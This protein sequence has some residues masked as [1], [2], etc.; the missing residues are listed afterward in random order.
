MKRLAPAEKNDPNS[1]EDPTEPIS[2]PADIALE[3][4]ETAQESAQTDKASDEDEL[5]VTRYLFPSFLD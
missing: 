3:T 5:A 2:N 1:L 4:G